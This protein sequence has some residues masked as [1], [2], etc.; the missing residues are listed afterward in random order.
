[1]RTLKEISLEII[2]D[3]KTINNT[4]ALEALECMKKMGMV[5]ERFMTDSNG[6]SIVGSFLT[7]SRGWRGKVARRVKEELRELSRLK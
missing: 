1:M 4:G 3:W 6:Y 5:T 7:H 2:S